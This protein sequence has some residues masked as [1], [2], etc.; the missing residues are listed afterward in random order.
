MFMIRAL[1]R[2]I[3][4]VV[5]LFLVFTFS[6]IGFPE[7]RIE[8]TAEAAA[9]TPLP[10]D[11]LPIEYIS[12]TALP[13]TTLANAPQPATSA[14]ETP[15]KPAFILAPTKVEAAWRDWMA[16]HKVNKSAM[17][18]GANGAIVHTANA[19]RTVDAAYPVASLS[20]AV[21]AMCL[22]A[23]L[24][25]SPHNWSTPLGDLENVWARL[26]MKPHPELAALPLA[27]LVTHTSGFPKNIDVDET[28]GEGRNL[29]TQIHFARSALRD[30]RHLGSKRKHTY[31]NVNFA[32]LGQIIEGLSGQPYGDI[33]YQTIMAPAGAQ[34]ANVGGRM[35]ATAGFGGWSVSASDY[36]RFV[37]HWYGPERPWVA[38][39]KAY[40]YD[41]KSGAG[42]GVFHRYTDDQHTLHHTGLWR[43]KK[44]E[45]RIGAM[46]V[47]SATGTVFV[48]N[49]QGSL[50]SKAYNDLRQSITAALH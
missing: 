10:E 28:A 31:S 19:G 14:P 43:S 20:K 37:M 45:R 42:V 4:A 35:W 32:L 46:F 39:P 44:P 26:A 48:A 15:E 47:T 50:P 12:R 1:I 41:R 6:P 40:P 24:E 17:S 9:Q 16:R 13:K 23:L 8:R 3:L 7:I 36:A 49:W 5:I 30:P 21:T 38:T 27:A 33:C 18:I 11:A 25:G 34:T 29:Y 2:G 22:N